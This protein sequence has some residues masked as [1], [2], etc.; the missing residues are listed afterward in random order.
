MLIR[1]PNLVSWDWSLEKIQISSFNWRILFVQIWSCTLF[2]WK[3]CCYSCR[4]IFQGAITW[5]ARVRLV[6]WTRKQVRLLYANCVK[7]NCLHQQPY[8]SG[9]QLWCTSKIPCNWHARSFLFCIRHFYINCCVY[10]LFF[11]REECFVKG[12]EHDL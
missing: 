12:S 11:V 5:K 3:C 2:L 8:L 9:H 6:Q 10:T 4:S 1:C 7:V